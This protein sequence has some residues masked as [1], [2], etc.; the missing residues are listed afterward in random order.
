MPANTTGCSAAT[1]MSIFSKIESVDPSIPAGAR[2]LRLFRVG[3]AG[4]GGEKTGRRAFSGPEVR[5]FPGRV[6]NRNEDARD[7]S[8]RGVLGET[9]WLNAC[10]GFWSVLDGMLFFLQYDGLGS[11]GAGFAIINCSKKNMKKN[12]R[13]GYD[14][15]GSFGSGGTELFQEKGWLCRRNRR[16]ELR[17]ITAYFPVSAFYSNFGNTKL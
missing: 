4:W 16:A 2:R 14:A 8:D 17:L 13:I 6:A 11:S 3:E 5:L 15:A 1:S 12:M 9:G 10:C 7:D